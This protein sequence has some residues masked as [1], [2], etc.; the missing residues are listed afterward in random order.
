MVGCRPN[1][2]DEADNAYQALLES[3][4]QM[5][6]ALQKQH[7]QIREDE[8]AIR[9]V[10]A[11]AAPDGAGSV[12]NWVERALAKYQTALFPR[13]IARKAATGRYDVRFYVF[14]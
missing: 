4:R 8:A 13:W 11:Y 1:R 10:Q 12:S 5:R 9:F 3:E 7:G 2:Q 14:W 6:E